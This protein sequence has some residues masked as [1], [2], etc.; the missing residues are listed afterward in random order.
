M[1]LNETKPRYSKEDL[2][3]FKKNI[4]EKLK[5][6]NEN[7]SFLAKLLANS[8]RKGNESEKAAL[9][10]LIDRQNKLI[11][12]LESALEKVK[13]GNYGICLATGKLINK[14]RLRLIPYV[15]EAVHE[16]KNKNLDFS[17]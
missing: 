4:V 12:K 1:P 8:E 10:Q 9:N 2:E 14:D 7:I 15:N 11:D 13:N 17:L 5:K 3:E 6:S 16:Q